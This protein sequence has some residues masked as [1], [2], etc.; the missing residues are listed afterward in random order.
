MDGNKGSWLLSKRRFL[1]RGA[2][3]FREFLLKYTRFLGLKIAD[4]L[5]TLGYTIKTSHVFNNVDLKT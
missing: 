5:V 2:V 3:G 1:K 4:I